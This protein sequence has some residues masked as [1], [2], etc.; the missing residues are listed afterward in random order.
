[1]YL[2]LLSNSSWG[3]SG[4]ESDF[5]FEGECFSAVKERIQ[6]EPSITRRSVKSTTQ[7]LA[8]QKHVEKHQNTKH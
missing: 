3:F 7:N 5:L 2:L 1:M 6:S 8:Q 4:L